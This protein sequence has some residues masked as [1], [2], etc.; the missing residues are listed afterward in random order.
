M[1]RVLVAL[2]VCSCGP[3]VSVYTPPTSDVACET[4]NGIVVMKPV[5]I[6][7]CDEVQGVEDRIFQA[8]RDVARVDS[9]AGA[10]ADCFATTEIGRATG[11]CPDQSTQ[12]FIGER[13]SE[14]FQT[15][16][17]YDVFRVY[18]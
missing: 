12:V 14:T 1:F 17:S 13:Y 7:W 4:D 2:L 3:S 15:S 5:P 9:C 8:F 18:Q 6:G 10:V 11:D 16:A